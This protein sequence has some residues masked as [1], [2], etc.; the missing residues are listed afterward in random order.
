M[1]YHLYSVVGSTRKRISDG[2]AK[3]EI[4]MDAG[5]LWLS[6]EGYEIAENWFNVGVFHVLIYRGLN[7]PGLGRLIIEP[8]RAK[9]A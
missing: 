9:D 2:H 1:T 6:T 4:A 8:E 5:N 7:R 3:P